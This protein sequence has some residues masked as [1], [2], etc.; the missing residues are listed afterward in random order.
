MLV[1]FNVVMLGLDAAA[2]AF[3]AALKSRAAVATAVV[4]GALAMLGLIAITGEANS[5]SCGSSAAACS[6]MGRWSRSPCF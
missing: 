6:S 3:V 4:G 1:L 2:I 5:A